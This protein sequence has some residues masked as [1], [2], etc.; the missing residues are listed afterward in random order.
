MTLLKNGQIANCCGPNAM[1]TLMEY[2][3]DYASEETRRKG[4]AMIR[5]SLDSIPHPK[6][7]GKTEEYLRKIGNGERDFRF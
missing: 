4:L 7:R 2:L 5:S 3:Q 6:V 1:L